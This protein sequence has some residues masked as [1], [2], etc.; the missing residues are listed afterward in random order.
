[1][2]TRS[3][4][5]NGKHINTI[6]SSDL[7]FGNKLHEINLNNDECIFINE[8]YYAHHDSLKDLHTEEETNC[9]LHGMWLNIK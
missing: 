1:M 5:I 8:H 7:E 6:Q 3:R 2:E 9:C 4:N